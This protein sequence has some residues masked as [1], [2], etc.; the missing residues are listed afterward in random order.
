MWRIDKFLVWK[1]YMKK[2]IVQQ[3]TL[4]STC[5]DDKIGFYHTSSC[6]SLP[7]LPFLTLRSHTCSHLLTTRSVDV[8]RGWRAGAVVEMLPIGVRSRNQYS[9]N[10]ITAKSRTLSLS[11]P[12][13][14]SPHSLLWTEG[15][16]A[17]FLIKSLHNDISGGATHSALCASNRVQPW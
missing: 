5:Q 9:A 11:L 8:N 4:V 15:A 13:C 2:K 16:K 12:R 7:P 1:K 6:S 14:L 17:T 10:M 3:S